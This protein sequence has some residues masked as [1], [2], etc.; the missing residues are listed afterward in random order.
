LALAAALL[1]AA[2]VD[3]RA[4]GSREGMRMPDFPYAGQGPFV[5]APAKFVS[6]IPAQAGFLA[7]ELVCLPVS[8]AQGDEVAP[9]KQ[10][11]LVCGRGLG[12]ALGWPVYA[13][14]GLP[15]FVLKET[16]WDFPRAVGSL[17][18][19]SPR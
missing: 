18:R 15:F 12:V 9:D 16:F 17:F 14:V 5:V 3:A 13:A 7:G 4:N 8:I 6:S 10:A 1:L 2:R 11:S 19:S